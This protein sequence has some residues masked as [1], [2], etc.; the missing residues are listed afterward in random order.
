MSRRDPHIVTARPNNRIL[1]R[2]LPAHVTR[3]YEESYDFSSVD[4]VP[5]INCACNNYAGFADLEYGTESVISRA[6]QTL[7][8]VPAPKGLED[9]V[10]TECAR[11]LSCEVCVTVPSG[12]G[13]NVAAFASVT[14]AAKRQ[15]RKCVILCDADCH[16]SMFT[17]AFYC[18]DASVH[19]FAHND[20]T[21]LE[22]KLRMY[23]EQAPDTSVCVAVEGIYRYVKTS[24]KPS[25]AK[26]GSTTVPR[27]G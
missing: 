3:R 27:E 11:F 25:I 2:L 18:K 20:L 6:L 9:T 5:L 21:D 24:R 17:G 19:R 12:Y 10:R 8:F 26:R 1:T 13:T 23:R 7:P 15:G 22:F 4:P 16:N 14:A